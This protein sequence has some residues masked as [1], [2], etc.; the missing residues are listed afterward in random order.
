MSVANIILDELAREPI[1]DKLQRWLDVIN[2]CG[3]ALEILA[4][5]YPVDW[6]SRLDAYNEMIKEMNL[7]K[8]LYK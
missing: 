8:E 7:T 3:E 2:D 1:K 5:D 6:Q 4:E